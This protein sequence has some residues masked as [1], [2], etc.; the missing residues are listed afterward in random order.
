MLVAIT[1][2]IMKLLF[3]I[4]VVGQQHVPKP[5]KLLIIGNHESF[6][7]GFIM[8]LFLPVRTTFVVH[9][10][11][12][13]NP[14]FRWILKHVPHLPVDTN[15]PLAM[16]KVI[17]LL[18]AGESVMIFPEGRITLTGSLMKAYDGP[19]FVAAKT[20]ATILPVRIHG[21]ARSYFSRLASDYPHSLLPKIRLTILPP[22]HIPMPEAPSAKQR[23]RIAGERM[24]AILQDLM[25]RSE[26]SNT[27]YGALLQAIRIYGRKH[28]LV[29]D[30]QLVEE[31]YG[32]VLKK[33]LALGRLVSK[34]SA[35][36]DTLA[37]LMP[38]VTNTVCLIFGMSAMGR[39]P[40]MLNYTAG[41]SGMQ[42]ACTAANIKTVIT[43]RKFIEAAKLEEVVAKLAGLEIFY[44]E[45]MRA[46]FSWRDK[47]WLVAYALRCPARIA[48][49]HNVDAPAVVLFTS[50]SEGKP[51]GVVHSHRGILANI[52]QIRAVIDFSHRD[53]FMMALPMFHSFGFTCG[54]IMPLV[55][56]S[57]V[58]IYP[59]PLHYRIIPEV[60]YERGC[61]ALFGTS[62]FLGN[63][64]KFAHPYDFYKMR[65]VIAGA[66]KLN[67]E[68]RKTWM[69]KFGIRILEGYGVTE[70]A[71]VLAVNTPMASQIGTVG[72]LL[73]GIEMRLEEVPGITEGGLL[74]VKGPNIMLGYLLYAQ[75][76]VL[77]PTAEGWHDTGDIVSV[78]ARGFIT[79]QG[80]VKRFAKIAGEMVSLET[81]E[82][83]ARLCSPEQQHAAT[84]RVDA[85]RGET[86]LLYTTDPELAREALSQAAKKLGHTELAVPRK[87]IV[88]KTL[89]LLGTGKIDYVTLKKMAETS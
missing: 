63:Y 11:V 14:L 33:S 68:V 28:K 4:E 50:G 58:F 2:T 67:S 77:Q 9:T 5:E 49:Q 69:E 30:M 51:K 59:S 48:Q 6:L 53:K 44:L 12:L 13:E 20:G 80:R 73:P 57:K 76:G 17:R 54:A 42:D 89:P 40:A 75:P 34:I 55:S 79:I 3:R 70:T 21:A 35:P 19:A 86:I 23:R 39:V 74:K 15:S 10:T 8:G 72:Q 60:I 7:D 62:T 83:L 65:Y 18:E 25:F 78:D 16:K 71:P 31:D 81:V 27:L 36:G 64:A 43:S 29:E 47:L 84:T 88:V 52:A 41:T 82:S 22:T 61:T 37:V 45:D 87:I 1:R 32:S 26:P 56:G 85:Q 24:Q 66:E 38:N 46:G